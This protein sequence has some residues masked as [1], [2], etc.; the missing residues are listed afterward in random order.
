MNTSKQRIRNEKANVNINRVVY[1]SKPLSWKKESNSAVSLFK[2]CYVLEKLRNYL[3]LKDYMA[4]MACSKR[5]YSK[6]SIVKKI[7][8]TVL[9]G[10][11]N[12]QRVKYWKKQCEVERLKQ[13]AILSYADYKRANYGVTYEMRKDLQ[14]ISSLENPFHLSKQ[15]I[16][17]LESVLKA[18]AVK[19]MDIQYTQGLNFIAGTLLLILANEEVSCL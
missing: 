2:Q 11:S 13:E 1:T 10:L 9:E 4:L 8:Q 3:S 18:F 7:E 19:N 15:S 14:R 16:E 6:A 5:I 12:E 17:K